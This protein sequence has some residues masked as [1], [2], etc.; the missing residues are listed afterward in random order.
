[1]PISDQDAVKFGLLAMYAEDMY[2]DG[3]K[4]PAVDPRIKEAGWVAIAYLTARDAILPKRVSLLPGQKQCI[5]LGITVFMAFSRARLQTR[6]NMPSQ[7]AARR[8]SRS[9]SSTPNFSRSPIRGS[10]EPRSSWDFGAF[11]KA[12]I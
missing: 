2:S 5:E 1:M 6:M 11:M 4:T 3:A 10:R 12:W 8:G 9:G 7:F